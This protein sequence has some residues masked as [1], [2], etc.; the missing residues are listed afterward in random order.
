MKARTLLV[1]PLI[2]ALT[3]VGACTKGDQPE[4]TPGPTGPTVPAVAAVDANGQPREALQPGGELRLAVPGLASTWNPLSVSGSS[5]E[6]ASVREA[7]LPTLFEFDGAG[8]ATPNPAFLAGADQTSDAP[9]TVRL[10]LNPQAVWGDG[11][12]ITWADVKATLE[13]CNGSHKDFRCATTTGFDQVA[14]ITQG[15]DEFQ[16]IVTFKRTYVDWQ[17]LLTTVVRADSV[18]DARAFGSGWSFPPAAWTS[19]PFVL[20]GYDAPTTTLAA[21]PNP[22]WWADAP[23]LERI[24]WHAMTPAEAAQAY[25][26]GQI[27]SY[28]VAD[29]MTDVDTLAKTADSTVHT[30]LGPQVRMLVF[31][32]SR[33]ALKDTDVRRG[34][35]LALDRQA[36]GTAALTGLG[37]PSLPVNNHVF[38]L[39]DPGYVDQAEAT[40]VKPD[41]AQ[42][43][44]ALD[45]AG[46]T[47][48]GTR[49]RKGKELTLDLAVPAGS[50]AAE[51]EATTIVTQLKAVGV[52]VNVVQVS[53]N[54]QASQTLATS[55]DFDLALVNQGPSAFPLD[56]GGRY[57]SKQ[58]TNL[59]GVNQSAID[60]Q[61]ATIEQ[62]TDPAQRTQLAN[63]VARTLW[64]QLDGIPL[65]QRPQIVVTR[66]GLANFG[67][68]GRGS[69][70]WVNVGYQQT[71]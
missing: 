41:P 50:P 6:M 16:A 53:G 51:A 36:I 49:Q 55:R 24:T 66:G 13:A 22:R 34:V 67:A 2:A 47:G 9:T 23:L 14:S 39:S 70:N 60:R 31:N 44:A 58:A 40:G 26:N 61:I 38:A 25:T 28:Q 8:T 52:G 33:G 71:A 10:S 1:A 37:W 65:Y 35:G 3:L 32:S 56:L 27:D 5:A 63:E 46:W 57:A 18:K 12:P 4:E 68:L 59:T 62:T 64:T 15:S 45:Q 17:R 11:R 20:G 43:A 7:I 19:G 42:A 69:I 48:S 54:D 30:A 21:V 29:A